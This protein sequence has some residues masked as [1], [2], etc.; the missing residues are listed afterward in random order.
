M[1]GRIKIFSALFLHRDHK[2]RWWRPF[3]MQQR[4]HENKKNNEN[5][6][7]CTLITT[8]TCGHCWPSLFTAQTHVKPAHCCHCWQIKFYVSNKR[9]VAESTFATRKSR[10]RTIT[11]NKKCA[12]ASSMVVFQRVRHFSADCS[13]CSNTIGHR[14]GMAFLAAGC[15]YKL[16][17]H[18]YREESVKQHKE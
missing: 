14:C 7:A 13:R 16:R 4:Q 9:Y 5:H 6:L 3:R 8:G 15:K 17:S 2:W 11:N 10:P 18:F 1:N 12:K